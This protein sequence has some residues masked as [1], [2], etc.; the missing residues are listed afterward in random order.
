MRFIPSAFHG[1]LDYAVALTLIAGPFVLGFEGVATYLSVA[2]G[3]GLFLYSL[4]TDY[5][6][7]VQNILPFGVHLAID[8]VAA[9][10]LLVAPFVF[11]FTGLTQL[12]YQGIGAAVAIVVI[13]T[14]P[15]VGH[16]DA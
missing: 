2:G 8:F 16:S 1:F 4:I 14:N 5:S 6:T 13:F 7:S 9:I 3:L 10:V 12:F 11:G 15:N